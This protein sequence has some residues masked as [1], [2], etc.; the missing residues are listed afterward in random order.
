MFPS[1]VEKITH[2]A[3]TAQVKNVY[4][5]HNLS[6]PSRLYYAITPIMKSLHS[7]TKNL[8]N[9]MAIFMPIHACV[10]KE[11][12]SPSATSIFLWLCCSQFA[13]CILPHSVP[14]NKALVSRGFAHAAPGMSPSFQ[15]LYFCCLGKHNQTETHF[16]TN[17]P[18]M[19]GENSVTSCCIVLAFRL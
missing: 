8:N 12:E 19:Q 18:L 4:I 10:Q 1:F 16:K 6:R 9:R 5:R 7:H 13:F 11:G 17:F 2:K 15:K 14:R 3:S